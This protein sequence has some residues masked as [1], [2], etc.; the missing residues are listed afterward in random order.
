[1]QS[2]LYSGQVCVC[3]LKGVGSVR[4]PV[5]CQGSHSQLWVGIFNV[6]LLYHVEK[7]IVERLILYCHKQ[8]FT[9]LCATSGW[10]VPGG[11]SNFLGL[12]EVMCGKGVYHFNKHPSWKP[13][14][15]PYESPVIITVLKRLVIGICEFGRGKSA[16]TLFDLY[17]LT[18]KAD[19]LYA[20][21]HFLGWH[22]LFE[23]AKCRRIMLLKK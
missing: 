9:N 12:K 14:F 18:R 3:T 1:M 5:Q 10:C 13:T 11:F 15:L 20:Y 7:T 6:Y 16:I 17:H 2:F 19:F 23:A 4:L 8:L 22:L 21:W